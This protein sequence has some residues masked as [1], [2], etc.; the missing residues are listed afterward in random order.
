VG[1]AIAEQKWLLEHGRDASADQD[2]FLAQR[3]TD[4]AAYLES[5]LPAENHWVIRHIKGEFGREVK[6]RRVAL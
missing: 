1:L 2:T 5:R 3:P 4:I 6:R